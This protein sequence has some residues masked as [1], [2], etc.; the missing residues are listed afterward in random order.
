VQEQLIRAVPT[1]GAEGFEGAGSAARRERFGPAGS[2][3][4]VMS[5]ETRRSRS[6]VLGCFGTEGAVRCDT[7]TLRTCKEGTVRGGDKGCRV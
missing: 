6:K 7:W 5:Q 4:G 3:T 2:G 1:F